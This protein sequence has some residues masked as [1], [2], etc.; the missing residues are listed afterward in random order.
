MNSVI[1]PSDQAAIREL[2]ASY[3]QAW[4]HSDIEALSSHWSIDHFRF[5]KAEEIEH[6]ILEWPEVIAYLKRNEKL[7]DLVH[8]QFLKFEFVSISPGLVIS[9]I[10]MRWDIQ[11][12]VNATLPD[13]SAFPHRGKAMGGDDHV[14]GLVERI[15]SA[16]KLVGWSETPDSP[17]TYMRQ[18]YFQNVKPGFPPKAR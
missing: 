4:V 1:S 15:G 13:G 14:L 18:L 10:H 9:I 17:I 5:Y 7:H 2:F 16:W 8:N 6:F 12:G 11:Y 3:S